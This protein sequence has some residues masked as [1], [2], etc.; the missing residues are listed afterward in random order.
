[1]ETDL[2]TATP[3]NRVVAN[4]L[5]IIVFSIAL[6]IVSTPFIGKVGG[7]QDRKIKLGSL[8][9]R[10]VNL[11]K[12]NFI[13][14]P[15]ALYSNTFDLV[16]PGSETYLLYSNWHLRS[17]CQ[18]SFATLIVTAFFNIFIVTSNR[19]LNR[20]LPVS[21]HVGVES[22]LGLNVVPEVKVINYLT[23]VVEPQTP[24]IVDVVT[25]H[26]KITVTHTVI[27]RSPQL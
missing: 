17:I 12:V 8:T 15:P 20:R 21:C 22:S 6:P 23:L 18:E 25:L 10:N 5:P 4:F 2:D 13:L 16:E 9:K 27:E 1:M 26:W 11:G 3:R 24:L 14:R 19:E 7:V